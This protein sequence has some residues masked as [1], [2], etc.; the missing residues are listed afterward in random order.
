MTPQGIIAAIISCHIKGIGKVMAGRIADYYGDKTIERLTSKNYDPTGDKIEGLGPKRMEA[1]RRRMTQLFGNDT[2]AKER[3]ENR[4]RL[5][6][7]IRWGDLGVS[8]IQRR[9]IEAAYGLKAL[10]VINDNPYCLTSI[11]GI[12]FRRADEIARAA[13]FTADDPRRIRAALLYVMEE[14]KCRQQGN[15]CCDPEV[16]VMRTACQQVLG[17]KPDQV[18][19][20]LA[21]C[22][23]DGTLSQSLGAI[24][25]PHMLEAEQEVAD[26]LRELINFKGTRI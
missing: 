8:F 18:R 26:R 23:A 11:S 10:D 14:E 13:G 1:L 17:V 22:L 12:G 24:Y 3:R 15:T 7:E 6:Q 16:L 5:Q 2:T 25:L 9:D 4:L 21:D 20:V 19:P